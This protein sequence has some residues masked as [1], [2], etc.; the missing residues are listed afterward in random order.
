[1]RYGKRIA[2]NVCNCQ[3]C[4]K[5]F[6]ATRKDAKFCGVNCRMQFHRIAKAGNGKTWHHV[7]D[8]AKAMAMD[9]KSVSEVAYTAIA[10]LLKE[11]GA[12]AAENAILAAYTAIADCM[13]IVDATNER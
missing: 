4:Q 6:Y 10:T 13:R 1:M 3:Q 8:S 5:P 11:F 7:S 12:R 2:Q 9:V